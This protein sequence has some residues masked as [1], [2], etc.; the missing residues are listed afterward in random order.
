VG[1]LRTAVGAACATLLLAVGGGLLTPASAAPAAGG[2]SAASS[3][4]R[5]SLQPT[6]TCPQDAVNQLDQ[7]I[8]FV[9][10]QT[11]AD[12]PG[13]TPLNIVPDLIACQVTLKV[14]HLSHHEQAAL[15][16]GAGPRLAIVHPRDFA[17]PS[18]VLLI[19][20]IVFGGAGLVWLY[21]RYFTA[22]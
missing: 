8:T 11:W 19:L 15:E 14:G 21:R 4:A 20:W 18:K 10:G 1:A 13:S 2:S 7:A 3:A 12:K 16:A 5:I 17:K 22:A 9:Q 6:S